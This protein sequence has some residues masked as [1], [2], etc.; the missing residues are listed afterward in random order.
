MILVPHLDP[1][2]GAGTVDR[3]VHKQYNWCTIMWHFRDLR[4]MKHVLFI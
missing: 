4:P 3:D 1:D 2:L